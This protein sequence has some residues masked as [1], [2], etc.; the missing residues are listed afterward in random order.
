MHLF[1]PTLK[2]ERCLPALAVQEEL[3]MLQF[4]IKTE[5]L[6]ADLDKPIYIKIPKGLVVS[7]KNKVLL[8]MRAFYGLKQA[9][10]QW[11]KKFTAFLAK[12]KL[13]KFHTE[14]S[15]FV[16]ITG[17]EILILAM[18]VDDGRFFATDIEDIQEVMSAR[19]KEFKVS[20]D[21]DMYS[22]VKKFAL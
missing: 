3:E 18:F 6:F 19:H 7:D 1:S 16:R 11:N 20:I 9:P 2:Y 12:F 4:D 5:F 14:W 17:N 10:H 15:V 22:L 8:L 21:E 13:V